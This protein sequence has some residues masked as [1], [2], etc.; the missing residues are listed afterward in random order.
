MTSTSIEASSLA[1][2]RAGTG[3]RVSPLV[4]WALYA[5]A[6]S[7]PLEVPDRFAF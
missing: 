1:A 5:T 6:F 2:S 4:R 7:I 3:T